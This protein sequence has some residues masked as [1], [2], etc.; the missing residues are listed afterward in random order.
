MIV[1]LPPAKLF[2]PLTVSP[3]ARVSVTWTLLPVVFANTSVA[4]D[5]NIAPPDPTPPVDFSVS[6]P[7]VVSAFAPATIDVPDTVRFFAPMFTAFGVIVTA[8]DVTVGTASSPTTIVTAVIW[9]RYAPVTL[10][11]LAPSMLVARPTAFGNKYAFPPVPAFTVP[12]I[13]TT[14]DRS[15]TFAPPAAGTFD[16]TLPVS[17]RLPPA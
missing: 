13:D 10:Y 16:A 7:V 3:P 2:V 8:P 17:V 15:V 12:A 9:L 14:S 4:T 11:A 6:V 1:T 5:V